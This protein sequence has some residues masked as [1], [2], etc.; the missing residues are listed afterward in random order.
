MGARSGSHS[1]KFNTFHRWV[2]EE[3]AVTT[4]EPF[5]PNQLFVVSAES[6]EDSIG[7]IRFCPHSVRFNTFHRWIFEEDAVTAWDNLLSAA[8]TTVP[9]EPLFL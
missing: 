8:D 4:W 5:S 2:V 1:V 9:Q 3:N 7:V 6:A